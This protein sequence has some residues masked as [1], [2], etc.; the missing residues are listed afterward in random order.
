MSTCP[1]AGATQSLA[2]ITLAPITLDPI[3]LPPSP[4]AP[5]TSDQALAQA[6]ADPVV[7]FY[8]MI[9]AA[10]PPQRAD[11]SAVGTLPTR[12]S[13]YC[14]AVTSASGFG[15]YVFPPMDFQLLF[16]GEEVFLDL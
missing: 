7:R 3:T 15:W 8:R 9:A 6:A 1:Y 13:R 11:R 2:P 12:A 14:D 5:I 4:L 16:D 10:R